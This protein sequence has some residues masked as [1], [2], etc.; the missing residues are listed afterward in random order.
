M[1]TSPKGDKSVFPEESPFEM[2][3]GELQDLEGLEEREIG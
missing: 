2:K 3:G 1:Q